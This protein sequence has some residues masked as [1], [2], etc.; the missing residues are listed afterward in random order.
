MMKDMKNLMS[1]RA[2]MYRF[3]GRLFRTEIDDGLLDG[4]K[5]AAYPDA[6]GSDTM[7]AGYALLKEALKTADTVL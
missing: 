2:A 1:G 5:T 7:D 6:T 4:L 3:L